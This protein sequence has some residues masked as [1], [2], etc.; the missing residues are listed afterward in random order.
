MLCVVCWLVVCSL[1]F[2][3]FAGCLLLAVFGGC[4][5]VVGWCSSFGVCGLLLVVVCLLFVV[6][7]F[8]VR[9]LLLVGCCSWF[10]VRCSL[11]VVYVWLLVVGCWCGLRCFF[12]FVFVFFS[13]CSWCVVAV[14]VIC[15]GLRDC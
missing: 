8:G 9:C 6:G 7:C 2:W 3:V 13:I 15:R 1:L 14:V 12:L 4:L 10:V 11:F 5:L